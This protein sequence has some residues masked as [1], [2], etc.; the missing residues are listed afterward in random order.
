PVAHDARG[1]PGERTIPDRGAAMECDRLDIDFIGARDTQVPKNFA[2]RP[3]ILTLVH[4]SLY[5]YSAFPGCQARPGLR[6]A[7]QCRYL[8]DTRVCGTG[9]SRRLRIAVVATQI[10]TIPAA[11]PQLS[12]CDK[13]SVQGLRS[14]GH[15][16]R[17]QP[18]DCAAGAPLPSP[19]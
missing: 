4:R 10:K 18:A 19:A 1:A 8:S 6:A 16:P 7:I 11:E 3:E 5:L 13:F 12:G 14:A 2:G 15:T 17:G 9:R